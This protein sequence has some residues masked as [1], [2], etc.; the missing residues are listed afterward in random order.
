[1]INIEQIIKDVSARLNENRDDVELVCKHVFKVV[2]D[3]MKDDN[4]TRDILLNGL[5]KFK[6]K[7]RY[8]QNKTIQYSSK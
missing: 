8:K 2:E 6:L 5:M 4:D 1:M 3:T 7:R